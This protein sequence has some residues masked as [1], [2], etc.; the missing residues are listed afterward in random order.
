MDYDLVFVGAEVIDLESGKLSRRNVYI[1]G[2][3]IRKVAATGTSDSYSA[4][5]SIPAHGYYLLPGFW[6]NHVHFRGGEALIDQNKKFLNLFLTHGIT[7]VRDAGG[8]L[9]PSIKQW[10]NEIANGLPGPT[11]F[12][13]GPKIDGPNPSWAGSLEINSAEDIPTALDSLETLGVDFVKLYDSRISAEHYL[14]TLRQIENRN[15]ISSGHM[16]FSVTLEETVEAG[17]DAIEHLYYVMKGCSAV[18]ADIT[19]AIREGKM[20]FWQAMP[21]LQQGYTD[22]TAQKAFKMLRK[23]DVY[24]VPTL[25]I[26]RTLS[27]LDESDHSKDPYL[28]YLDAEFLDTYQGRIN[29]FL[30]A[31]DKARKNRKELDDFFRQLTTELHRAEVG[32][33]A[34]SDCGAYNSYVYPGPSLHD[35]L[36]A[37]VSCGL[38]ELEALRTSAYNGAQFLKKESEY[39]TVSEGK[40]ADLVLLSSNPLDDIRNTRKIHAVIKQGKLYTQADLKNLLTTN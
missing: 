25:H 22:S 36:E 34:G 21:Q 39:G 35:E 20:G 4:K 33:L 18:E 37:L 17:I 27:Y 7:T 30:R 13:S 40:K 31:T 38:N 6:D 16:P 23:Q 9:T 24:V 2:G 14:E 8:D 12:T 29:S 3:I 10:Q 26:G 28:N 1:S 19:N 5:K 32:L 11:I 15:L